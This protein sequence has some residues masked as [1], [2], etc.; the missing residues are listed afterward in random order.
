MARQASPLAV[1]NKTGP[2]R[3][4]AN[5]GR[6]LLVEDRIE[7]LEL[8]QKSLELAGYRVVPSPSGD[9]AKDIFLE[10]GPYDLLVTDICL[11]GVLQ[12]ARLAADLRELH[13]DLRIIFVSGH[14]SDAFDGLNSLAD[15]PL[16][17]KPVSRGQLLTA[18]EDALSFS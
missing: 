5:R 14:A 11:P 10:S 16:L 12:G 15:F 6:I 9:R 7:L 18:V 3:N 17:R 2:P 1:E 8:T 4:R 13:S